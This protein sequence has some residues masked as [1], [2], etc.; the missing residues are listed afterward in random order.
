A[1]MMPI[2]AANP[3][4][5]LP[6]YGT[7]VGNDLY[8]IANSQKNHYGQY[9]DLKDKDALEAVRIFR[10]NVRFAWNE[11]GIAGDNAVPVRQATLEEGR[12]MLEQGPS[13]QPTPQAPA[14]AEK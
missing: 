2:D 5:D 7:L 4:F 11:K 6:T 14:P 1:R 10:S 9:G 8:F 13:M 12:K 3:A